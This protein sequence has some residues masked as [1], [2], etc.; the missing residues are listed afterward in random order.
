MHTAGLFSIFSISPGTVAPE[1]Q[2]SAGVLLHIPQVWVSLF[3]G[4]PSF[5]FCFNLLRDKAVK[6]LIFNTV[7]HQ[8]YDKKWELACLFLVSCQLWLNGAVPVFSM[9]PRCWWGASL[10]CSSAEVKGWLGPHCGMLP[11]TPSTYHDPRT[12]PFHR[13][14]TRAAS[15]ECSKI[16][17]QAGLNVCCCLQSSSAMVP[18]P[19]GCHFS[20]GLIWLCGLWAK[21]MRFNPCRWATL[22]LG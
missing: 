10:S 17:V 12:V 11:A 9:D 15:A 5:T 22:S 8:C 21:W 19:T 1:F 18:G 7:F 16:S 20:F 14:P 6:D 13:A 3:P 2:S 4:R